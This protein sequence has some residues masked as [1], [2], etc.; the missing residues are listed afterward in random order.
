M[1]A[2]VV[3][4]D[5]ARGGWAIAE[6]GGTAGLSVCLAPTITSVTDRLQSGALTA[7]VVD[8]PIGLSDD[9]VR[10]AD[11]L[12]RAK[13]GVRRSTFFP[14]PVRA[15]LREE[16]WERANAVSRSAS[17]KG[18]SKQAWNLVPKIRELDEAWSEKLADLIVEGHPEVSFAQ[19]AGAPI[20]SKK[21]TA[22]GQAERTQLLA[23][24]LSPDAP[25]IVASCPTSWRIDAVDALALAWTA[26]RLASGNAVHLGGE[27]DAEG[28]PMQLVI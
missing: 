19:M 21:N 17:G 14:T 15:V 2:P 11:T 1:S 22:A 18:L 7:A 8:M 10:P 27:I 12:A 6:W 16:S 20:L 23:T 5:G 13:L 24:H 9:G 28:R 4:I 26:Q 3:G 25:T